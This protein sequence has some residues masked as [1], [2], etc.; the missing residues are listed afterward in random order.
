MRKEVLTL[1]EVLKVALLSYDTTLIV[2]SKNYTSL[3]IKD[4]ENINNDLCDLFIQQMNSNN[5]LI[6]D[7]NE[8]SKKEIVAIVKEFYL[9][10]IKYNKTLNKI[11][12]ENKMIKK[13]SKDILN[14]FNCNS[15]A[16]VLVS[17]DYNNFVIFNFNERYLDESIYEFE[18]IINN[19]TQTWTKKAI[20]EQVKDFFTNFKYYYKES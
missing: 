15:F 14:H 19:K 10:N 17:R 3:I 16:R 12:F 18:L 6:I 1:K 11:K 13:Y 9:N 8:L 2:F 4:F 20:K 5:H 7:K